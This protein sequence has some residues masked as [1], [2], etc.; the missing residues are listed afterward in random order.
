MTIIYVHGFGSSAKGGKANEFREYFKGLNQPFIAPSLSYV[1]ELAIQTLEE[2]IESYE[3]VAL[4]G[5]SLG[6]YYSLYLSQKHNLKSALINPSTQPAK[7]LKKALGYAPN[8]YDASRFEWNE[9]HLRSLEKFKTKITNQDNLMLL[10]QKGDETLNYQEALK[11][12]PN[13][14]LIVEDGGS[15]GFEGIGGHFETIANFLQLSE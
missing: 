2:L 9:S 11:L 5:S 13:S 7:T 15:H 8:F 12:L 10:V 3:N 1:P 6:G 14:T 4:I